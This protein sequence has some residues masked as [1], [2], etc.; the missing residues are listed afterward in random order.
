MEKRNGNLHSKPDCCI[1]FNIK[2][3][4][5]ETDSSKCMLRNMMLNEKFS[6]LKLF[7]GTY[8]NYHGTKILWGTIVF[9]K[10]YHSNT[11][12][13]FIIFFKYPEILE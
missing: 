8:K 10:M 12:L 1:L 11:I 13:T 3:E 5:K 9:L 7:C 2:P 6:Q 4:L